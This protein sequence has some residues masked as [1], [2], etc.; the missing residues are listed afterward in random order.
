MDSRDWMSDPTKK[1]EEYIRGVNEFLEFAFQNVEADGKIFCPCK[2]CANTHRHSRTNIYLHLTDPHRGFLRGYRQWI[3]HGERPT[4]PINSFPVVID[5]KKK[6]NKGVLPERHVVYIDTRTRKNGTI[7]NDKAVGVID[8][9]KKHV[10]EGETSQASQSKQGSTFWKDDLLAKVQGPKN[11]KRGRVRCLGKIPPAK[12]SKTSSSTDTDLREEVMQI[13]GLLINV[14]KLMQSR[15]PEEAVPNILQLAAEQVS[16]ASS[17]P[18]D[19]SNS[20]SQSS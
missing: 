12:K 18:N 4:I 15:L 10:S 2:K 7:V 19:Q 17:K 14:L 20:G 13:K 11:E 5:E 8:E 9:I 1:T 3:F 6:K 16:D